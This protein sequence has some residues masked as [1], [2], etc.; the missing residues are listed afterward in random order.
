MPSALL[1]R[2]S[3]ALQSG[4]RDYLELEDAESASADAVRAAK[5]ADEL[6]AELGSALAEKRRLEREL[7]TEETQSA[8]TQKA[9]SVIRLGREDL[10]RAALERKTQL[11]SER[12][13][14]LSHIS[15]LSERAGELEE[16][17]LNLSLSSDNGNLE[18]KLREL[19]S[20][21][22][23]AAPDAET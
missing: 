14:L 2:L 19:D 6:R 11:E 18:R 17:L 15:L 8:L 5:L 10:A 1:G 9:E 23:Q 22:D 21:L 16:I 20:L 13:A 12:R 4:L 7:Q 3:A